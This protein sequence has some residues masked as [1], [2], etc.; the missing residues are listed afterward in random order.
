M[1]HGD[2]RHK[3]HAQ[4]R[5]RGKLSATFNIPA[6]LAGQTQIAI[7]LQAKTGGWFAYNWF[8]NNTTAK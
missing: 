1:D 6:E 5:R 2:Q 7:R 4:Q 3:W 8:W